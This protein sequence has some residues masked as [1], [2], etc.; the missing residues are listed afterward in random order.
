MFRKNRL[1]MIA[2]V[3]LTL[4]LAAYNIPAQDYSWQKPHAKVLPTGDLEWAPEDFEY[5]PGEVIRY[6]DY[7]NGNDS[8]DGATQATAW[9]HH[10]WDE[11]FAGAEKSTQGVDTYVFKG[12]VIYRGTL[13]THE[14]GEAWRPIRLTR[15]PQWGEGPAWLVG[16]MAVTDGWKKADASIAPKGMPEPEKVWY[17]DFPEIMEPWCVWQRDGLDAQR[18]WLAR[19]PNWKISNPDFVMSEWYAFDGP[20]RDLPKS[21]GGAPIGSY[22]NWD[23]EFLKDPSKPKDFFKNARIW[24]MWSGGVF[25]AMGTP[26]DAEILDYDPE[27]GTIERGR[28]GGAFYFGM[29]GKD[30]RYYVERHP[31][32]LDSPGEFYFQLPEGAEDKKGEFGFTV[33]ARDRGGRLFIRLPGDRNP[34]ETTIEVGLEDRT[35]LITLI[36]TQNIEISGLRFS[37]LNVSDNYNF[38]IYPLPMRLPTAIQ[39]F[40]DCKDVTIRNND[41]YH[42]AK[43]VQGFT[44]LRKWYPP[45]E[46]QYGAGNYKGYERMERILVCDNSI[47]EADHGGISFE[48]GFAKLGMGLDGIT[49]LGE[50][51]ILRN[52]LHR[53]NFRPRPPS[54][55][56]NIPA[57][58][59]DSITLGEIAGNIVTRSWGVGIWTH[60]GRQHGVHEKPLIRGLIHHNKV[61]DSLLVTNDWGAIEN[62]T[63]GPVIIFNNLVGNPVGPHPHKE[64]DS[65]DHGNFRAY[66]H[67]GYAYYLDGGSHKKYL[68]NNIAWGK[69]NDPDSWYKNR[70]PQMMVNAGLCQWFNNSFYHFL[71]GAVGSSGSRSSSIGN[72]YAEMSTGYIALGM[73]NDISTAYGGEDPQDTLRIGLPTIAYGKNIFQGAD[74]K[75]R[76]TYRVGVKGGRGRI[77]TATEDLEEFRSFLK[78]NGAMASQAGYEIQDSPFKDGPGHDFR[79]SDAIPKDATA[80][81]YFVPFPLYMT[82]GE[83]DFSLNRREPSNIIGLNFFFSDE[84]LSAKQYYDVPWNNLSAPGATQEN[85]IDG[86]LENWTQSAFVLDGEHFAVFAHDVMT[87]DYKLSQG[88]LKDEENGTV[89]IIEEP[90]PDRKTGKV[91]EDKQ[92]QWDKAMTTY[93]GEKRRTVDMGTNN[94][95]VEIY[96]RPEAPGAIVS[97]SKDGVGYEVSMTPE[98]KAAI[99]LMAVKGKAGIVGKTAMNDSKWHHIIAE[100]DRSHGVMR[101]YIDG[102]LDGEGKIDLADDASLSNKGDFLVGKGNAGAFKGAVDYLRVSRGTLAD[103][104]TT[105]RE[106]YQWQFNGPFLRDFTGRKRDFENGA[107][108]AIDFE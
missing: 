63:G 67:N 26:Y 80:A 98:G 48:D 108:G 11:Q 90:T 14:S 45:A 19:S 2:L 70:S 72:I 58:S 91:P 5:S 82:V 68:F 24:T 78:E 77:G 13:V 57:I 71:T 73:S 94:F 107:P 18:I 66:S 101:V 17:R 51:K 1:S 92:A 33:P 56:L 85:Y 83:W 87:A 36:D 34:N 44:R 50:I 64:N 3:I 12:G 15:D 53:I 40:G 105:I 49:E 65:P 69:S 74:T 102:Q 76:R 20:S 22:K 39:M 106:L 6:I 97:K 43:A 30:D 55:G 29:G 79:P 46:G 89:K 31:A 23:D 81:K 16:S 95:L 32:F 9:K 54:P 84:F 37:F 38:P 104:H 35:R 21:E 25:S 4:A 88:V 52:R 86:P 100:V 7:E 75:A 59:I 42:A 27:T 8:N 60:G 28:I 10:P 41:F 62:N 47:V 93:P 96:A 99:D 61:V 103:A